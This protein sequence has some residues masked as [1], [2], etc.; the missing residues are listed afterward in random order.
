MKKNVLNYEP[1]LALFVDD[2]DPL[3]FYK[4]IASFA[5]DFMRS[6]GRIYCEINQ[7]LSKEVYDFF[8]DSKLGPVKLFKDLSGNDRILTVG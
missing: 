5:K 6:Q 7:Y 1:T 4:A 2:S 8:E 3:I